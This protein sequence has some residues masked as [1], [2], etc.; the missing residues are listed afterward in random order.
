MPAA[1]DQRE[2]DA[3]AIKAIRADLGR[4]RIFASKRFR[5]TTSEVILYYD[6]ER[7]FAEDEAVGR[8][9]RVLMADAPPRIEKFRL[10][11]KREQEFDVLRAPM[12]RAFSQNSSA[13]LLGDVITAGTAGL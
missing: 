11:A 10:I 8:L 2:A 1:R 6:N 4:S 7:Y 5:F 13:E 12:E 9:T 3:A